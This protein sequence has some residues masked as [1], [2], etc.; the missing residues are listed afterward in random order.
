VST[1]QI[2][3]GYSRSHR[4]VEITSITLVLGMLVMMAIRVGRAI[5]STGDWIYLGF[6]LL[7]GYLTAD[8]LSGVVHWA[9]DTLG[10]ETTPV[11]GKNFVMP[12]RQHHVDPKEIATHDII[13][14]NGN[15]CI[16]VLAPLAAAYFLMPSETGFW[17]FASTLMGFLAL[18]IVATNQFHKW[19]HSDTPPRFA[20]L[21]QRW[22]LILS[23]EHHN[24]HHAPPHDRH[25]CITVGW[26]NPILNR[27][28]F[29]RGVEAIVA[30]VR[31]DWLYLEERELFIANMNVANAASAGDATGQS[32]R[33]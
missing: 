7:T 28:Q 20:V 12:F 3:P 31:P 15:N 33:V 16:V 13:E 21:L 9:G 25:Y 19:A 1:A 14:T 23:P 26:M 30:A 27:I 24:I 17:F 4:A 5:E 6:T 2:R 29:F 8:F 10:D 32:R 18:F 11:I 22:G